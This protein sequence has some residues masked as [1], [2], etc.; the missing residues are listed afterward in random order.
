MA[1]P[2]LTTISPS[3][4][5]SKP[6]NH[7]KAYKP[8]PFKKEERD[9]VTILY[10]GLTWKHERL[11]QGI[12]SDKVLGPTWRQLFAEDKGVAPSLNWWEEPQKR[13]RLIDI[14]VRESAAFVYDMATL[15]KAVAA[16]ER[17]LGAEYF[18]ENK[19]HFWGL[20]ETRPYMRARYR[21]A[22]LLLDAGRASEAIGHLEAL[23]DLNPN[24]NQ[25]IRE[26]LLGPY[27]AGDR[28]DGARRLLLTYKDDDSAVFAWGRMLEKLLSGD[29]DRAAKLLQQARRN[30]RRALLLWKALRASFRSPRV[31]LHVLAIENEIE[32]SRKRNCNK[33]Q[34]LFASW[35]IFF[36]P[37]NQRID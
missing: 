11:I 4:N 33:L 14:A 27:L 23:L 25:G 1:S 35:E 7:Y 19:G 34:Q 28:L 24:D 16:G 5:P 6:V 31:A 10:G 15:E 26:V 21:L 37:Q 17:S 2:Q 20:M 8:R 22:D 12:G 3:M 30:N 32:S 13:R 36:H 18:E 9:K 29:F